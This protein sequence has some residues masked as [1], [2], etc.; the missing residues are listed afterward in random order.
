VNTADLLQH[1]RERVPE[2][3]A[4]PTEVFVVDALPLTAVGKVFKP[5]LRYDV[6]TKLFQSIVQECCGPDVQADVS[7]GPH[8][9]HGTAG[10]VQ[11]TGVAE[12]RRNDLER[13]MRERLGAFHIPFSFKWA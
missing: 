1:A 13:R 5:Q 7:V 11:L 6:A 4:V 3:A 8:P 2:R 10:A 12:G 9:T